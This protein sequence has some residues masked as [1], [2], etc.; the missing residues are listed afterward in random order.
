LWGSIIEYMVVNDL[1]QPSTSSPMWWAWSYK[2]TM[3]LQ[4]CVS[5]HKVSVSLD[6]LSR[7]IIRL[8]TRWSSSIGCKQVPGR[9][10]FI[11]VWSQENQQKIQQGLK[12]THISAARKLT[13]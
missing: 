13:R 12:K 11:R 9:R 10:K 7:A 8:E 5:T 6:A 3:V 4:C 2:R 1:W